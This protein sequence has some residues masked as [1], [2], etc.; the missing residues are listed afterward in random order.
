[1]FSKFTEEAQKVLITAKAEMSLLKHPYVGSE[2][3]LLAMLKNKDCTITKRLLDYD[4][5]YKKMKGEIVSIIGLGTETNDWFLYTPLLKRIL[6]GAMLE[7]KEDSDG[8]VT[9]EH[10]F[11]ALL[12]EG[13]GVA[14]RILLGMGIDLDDL[15]QS[16]STKL[17]HKKGKGNKK[18]SVEEFATDFN[19]K[20]LK[21]E[22]DPVVGRDLELSRVIEILSRRGKNNPLLIGEA[23]VGK[24]AIVEELARLIVN[25]MV[26]ESLKGKRILS[27]SM[28]GVVA[29]TKYR[30]EFEDRINKLLKEVEENQ[31][32]I[33]F[34]DEIHTLIGA[35]GAEGA[36]DASNILKPVLARGKMRLIGAT[37]TDEYKKFIETDKAFARRFQTVLVEEPDKNKT[38][39]ILKKLKTLYEGYHHVI[40]D[41]D[42]L[43]L[44]VD[45][46]DRY[47]FDRKQP[48]KAIDLMDEVCAKVALS[49]S[50]KTNKLEQLK[51]NY[52][53]IKKEKNNYIVRQDFKNASLFYEKE[54]KIENKINNLELKIASITCPKKVSKEFVIALIKEKTKIP[55]YEPG[56]FKNKD[57]MELE[58]NLGKE[59]IGQNRVISEL[60][61]ETKK[62]QFGLR[63]DGRPVSFL[64]VGSTGV[65]KTK[66]VKEYAKYLVG[67]EHLIRLDMSEYK[68]SHSISKIIGSPPGYVGYTDYSCVLEE[69][70]NY[71]YSIILLDEIEKAH[72][73]VLQLFLQALDEGKMKL[74]NGT[75]VRFDHAIIFM[76]SNIG[77]T[78][79][80][81]GFRK[82]GEISVLSKLEE[83]L[84]LEFI[85]RI[86]HILLFDK[87]T[88]AVAKQII[89]KKLHEVVQKFNHKGIQLSF[90]NLVKDSILAHTE[91][92]KFGA[93]NIERVIHKNLDNIIIDSIL[94][95]KKELKIKSLN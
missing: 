29:G 55:V 40:I 52:Q 18:L 7:A 41:D 38:Y 12:E 30:G 11:I 32:I 85:N 24:T 16:F 33:L 15:Y 17:I 27:L 50:D 60:C 37:T 25:D 86:E 59:I 54:K 20:V 10:L 36:I 6:E 92:N 13:E 81:L 61:L 65:G 69:L 45:L 89:D 90:S 19:S 14:I 5:D 4:L 46:S 42:L 93:R 83:F 72:P 53:E 91:Y 75:V 47:L 49:K 84:S 26:P 63:T 56:D 88:K 39:Q 77:F 43:E 48:D 64:F 3:L 87:I 79:K 51:S 95:G 34:V 58:I 2:H 80:N 1:M 82:E 76:T 21:N 70:R 74:S 57:F 68:E 35:G 71:P 31:E 28:A 44:I 62:M 9:I 66:L 22:M 67:E 94:A 78:S 23:G 73:E 8:E